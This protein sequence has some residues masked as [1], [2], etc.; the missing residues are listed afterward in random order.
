[1]QASRRTRIQLCG[2][3]AVELDGRRVEHLLPSRQGRL[4]FAYLALNSDRAVRRD[5]LIDCIWPE[6]PPADSAGA[7]S[8]LLSRLRKSVGTELIEGKEELSLALPP[9]AEIDLEIAKESLA[10]AR[11]AAAD[12]DWQATWCPAHAAL[13]IAQR[14]LLPGLEADWIDARRR[15]L[16]EIELEAL[17]LVAETGLGLGGAELPAAERAGKSLVER[18]PF[19]ESGYRLQMELLAQRGNFAQALQLYDELRQL[20]AA[21]LGT[22]PSPELLSLHKRLLEGTETADEAREAI[23]TRASAGMSRAV[24]PFVGRERELS[25]VDNLLVDARSARVGAVL[26]AGEPGIGKTRLAEQLALRAAAS[27]FDVCWGRC[28]EARGAPAF[29]PWIDALRSVVRRTAPQ[30]LRRALGGGGGDLLPLLPELKELFPQ[31]E[32]SSQADAELARFRL[33]DVVSQLLIRLAA[34]RP[35]LV[36]L[37]D[38]HYADAPSLELLRFL[39]ERRS[40]AP[41]LLCGTYRDTE[42]AA[43]L[44]DTLAELAYDPRVHRITLAGIDARDLSRLVSETTGQQVE[45][46]VAAALHDRT[47]GNPFFALELARLLASER[48]LGDDVVDHIH[49]ELPE[50]VRSV[51][52]RRLARLPEGTTQLLTVAAVT[53]ADFDLEPVV[54]AAELDEKAGLEN[55]EAALREHLIAE[56]PVASG[57]YRFTHDLIRETLYRDLSLPRRIALHRSVA[58]ALEQSRSGN[59]ERILQLAHHFYEGAAD[60][61]GAANKAHTYALRAAKHAVSALAYEQAE[62][63][64]R[65][66]LELVAFF[67]PGRERAQRELSVQ[68]ALGEFLMLTAGYADP[69]VGAACRRALELCREIGDDSQFLSS[70]WRLGVFHEVRAELDDSRAIGQ[71]L[72]DLGDRNERPEF[73]MAGNQLLGVATLLRGNLGAAREHLTETLTLADAFTDRPLAEIFGQDF[74][75]TSRCFLAWTLSLLADERAEPLATE[76]LALARLQGREPDEAFALCISSLAAVLR[77]AP[78]QS[79]TRADE[80]QELCARR[81]YPLL[82]AM[83]TIMHGWATAIERDP[84]AGAA[85]IENGIATFK[86]TGARMMLH[87]FLALLAEAE[88]RQGRHADALATIQDAL[89]QVE[90]NGG[91]YE[92]ELHRLRGELIATKDAGESSTNSVEPIRQAI[93][94]AHA[95]G[96]KALEARAN[97]SLAQL[98]AQ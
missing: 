84:H 68:V 90:P 19:R 11:A 62:E 93:A 88:G 91:F 7:L 71:Q 9:H 51:I 1:M 3:L 22:V 89:D 32:P 43:P 40:D 34:A 85:S 54:R 77:R 94:I 49:R 4:L 5:E 70:L 37:D 21:E 46:D 31:L 81:G 42:M 92:A 27:D 97:A 30:R 10:R 39:T 80:A 20:L 56:T 72:L 64:L 33:Y 2:R 14:G 35:L 48:T 47:D 8:T 58:E 75:V 96:A 61:A 16:E 76:A 57:R 18:A 28:D 44:A 60:D 67:S 53:G 69:H 73:R 26:I 45:E 38:L 95:Q 23:E 13:A 36:I 87:F 65:R 41:L 83:A 63:Q 24:R 12:R 50:G 74:R 98:I 86:S 29:W 59:G 55:A 79:R 6:R 78:R 66:A 15:E 25:L 82:G 52:R 17:E